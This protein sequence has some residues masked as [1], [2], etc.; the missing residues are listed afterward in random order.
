MQ[1]DYGSLESAAS[2]LKAAASQLR[3]DAALP[4]ELG[5]GA[6]APDGAYGTAVADRGSTKQRLAELMDAQSASCT[7]MV[8]LFQVLDA[9]IASQ[10]NT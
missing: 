8:T 2:S 1:V 6:A 10:L 4:G 5:S 9:Q 3:S 7:E